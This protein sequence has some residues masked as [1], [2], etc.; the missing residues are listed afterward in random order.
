VI[1]LGIETSCDETAAAVYDTALGLRS[2]CLYSQ[3]A[4]HAP[5][6]GVV[7]EL[8][9]RDHIRKLL[10]LI[11]RDMTEAG[12]TP[13]DLAGV[14]YTAGPGLVGALLVGATVGVGLAVG[15]GLPAIPVHHMEAHLL[16][17][18]LEDEPPAFPFVALLV[19]GGHTLLIEVSAAGRYRILGETLDDAATRPLLCEL[20]MEISSSRETNHRMRAL[21]ASAPRGSHLTPT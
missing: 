17:A 19:S 18:L 6:G 5:F 9:S 2:H 21:A 3:V 13:A 20:W 8:A 16:A 15:W 12:V 11:D 10:P 4:I 14:A 1:V 7:P